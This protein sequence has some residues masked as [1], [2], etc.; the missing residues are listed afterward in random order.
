MK[1]PPRVNGFHWQPVQHSR[2]FRLDNESIPGYRPNVSKAKREWLLSA[3]DLLFI[4]EG[5]GV[6]GTGKLKPHNGA[7][8]NC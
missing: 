4:S 6:L 3:T 8:E 5:V 1:Q 2:S 7:G